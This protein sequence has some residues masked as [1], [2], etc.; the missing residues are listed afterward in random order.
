MVMKM[1]LTRTGLRPLRATSLVIALAVLIIG[2]NLRVFAASCNGLSQL[3]C[4]AIYGGWTSWVPDDGS[5]SCGLPTDITT[6]GALEEF[7]I[8]QVTTFASEPVPSTWNISD[9]TAEQW[10]LKQSGARAT[11]TKY[12]LDS[13]NIGAITA[14]VKAANVSPI[15]FYLYTVNEGGGSGGFINHYPSDTA[16]GG[17]ANAARD[18]EYLASQSKETNGNPATGGGEPSDLPTTEA[19]QILNALPAGSIGVVYIQATSAVTAELEDLSGKTGDWSGLYGKPL[20]AAMQNIKTLGGD[21]QQGGAT[22]SSVGCTGIVGEGM[23]KGI[24]FAIA[25]ANN[26]GYGYDQSYDSDQTLP[27]PARETGWAR[28]QSDPSCTHQCGSLDCSSF[29]S[30][31]LTV[32]GYFKTNPNFA[33][34]DEPSKL[35]E[36]GFT[37]IADSAHTS[38]GLQPGDIL[39]ADDHHTE[40]YIGNGK[41]VRASEN[42]FNSTDGG[43]VGDQTGNE[44]SVVPF[45]DDA[46][47]AVYRAPN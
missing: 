9:S 3:D 34:G 40:M 18:A 22:L 7:T 8:D 24:N 17:P 31:I 20:S 4:Q 15:F 23:T 42:E 39:I 28:Y 36:A 27:G 44:I 14:A 2:P 47:D 11:I 13:S 25:I 35:E 6:S 5:S 45:N 33:T 16:G 38:S 26:N 41:D 37:K 32:A 1:R 19:Q 43:K 46:W 30:A 10:F 12:G 29:V 21:P